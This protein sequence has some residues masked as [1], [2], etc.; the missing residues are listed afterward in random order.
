MATVTLENL[1]KKFGETIATDSLNLH[2]KDK[3]FV[4]LLGPSGCG[5]TTTLRL[6]AGLELPTE[7]KIYMNDEDITYVHPKDRKASMVFQSYALY[8]HMTVFDNIAFPLKMKKLPKNEIRDKVRKLVELLQIGDLLNR[9]PKELSGG[10]RQRVALGRAIIK[11]PKIFLMD[12]PLS[13][14][15]AKLRVYLRGELK[16]LQKKLGITT[17][18]VTHDQL[19]AMALADRIAVMD[20]GKL[21][22]ID[23]ANKLY[24]NPAT[25][26]V[27]GFVGSPPMN[28]IGCSLEEKNGR[29][30]LNTGEF[31]LK[32]SDLTS[33]PDTLLVAT[34]SEFFLGVRP[35]S[36][37]ILKSK[38][39]AEF[40]ADIINIEPLGLQDV[41]I[42]KVG[43][44]LIRAIVL[45]GFGLKVGQ[46][47]NV[48]FDKRKLHIFDRNNGKCVLIK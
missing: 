31:T 27:A 3:E 18:Y 21:H 13:N 28:L 22:Q 24:N 16:N 5:K 39:G 42:L 4:V 11:E 14:V 25:S 20:K 47:V 32:V 26:F 41:L 43:D 46:K 33:D 34:S 29:L 36:I 8:P 10:Q 37:R 35:E 17:I 45:S 12:E 6:I 1:T 19:E 2:V 44:N 23:P 40:S 7:G 38:K 30:L 15:D 48:T 9:K